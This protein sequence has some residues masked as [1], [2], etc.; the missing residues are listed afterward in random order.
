MILNL[1]ALNYT[2]AMNLIRYI[3]D[4]YNL[5]ADDRVEKLGLFN[6]QNGKITTLLQDDALSIFKYKS[7]RSDEFVELPVVQELIAAIKT[8]GKFKG[9]NHIGFCY[10]VN[11]KKKAVADI[12]KKVG[13]KSCRVYQEP[14][15]DDAAWIFVGDISE[16]TNPLLEFLPHESD[17]N[18][19]WIDYWLPHIQFDIDTGLSSG[20]IYTLVK[21][22]IKRPDTPYSIK[23]DGITYIQRVNLGCLEG[24]NIMLDIS[25]NSRDINYRK[26]WDV[27]S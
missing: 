23:I 14:S 26:N 15:N 21:K 4:I 27:L 24:V 16:I 10:K 25:T 18:D 6:V 1:L 9:I 12:I 19:K 20:E 13:K 3:K 22:F 17:V 2:K 11:S 8:N 7:Q 5:L